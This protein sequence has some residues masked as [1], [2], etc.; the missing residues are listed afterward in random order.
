VQAACRDL[1]KEVFDM[2]QDERFVTH[3]TAHPQEVD[4]FI[5]GAGDG[6]DDKDLHFDMNGLYNNP[7]NLAVI[8]K[9]VEKFK[10]ARLAVPEAIRLPA[11]PDE[12]IKK[13]FL[14]KFKRC[15]VYW[16]AARPK[17]TD[18]GA[19]ESAKEVGTRIYA[20]KQADLKVQR[21][22]TRRLSVS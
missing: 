16:T 10:A 22:A 17:K 13:M 14:D 18:V 1:F 15:R 8:A 12:Y 2:S 7:W 19:T 9:L 21:H 6:P 20:K 11:R 5:N 4:D 3:Q